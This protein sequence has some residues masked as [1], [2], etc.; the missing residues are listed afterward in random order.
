MKPQYTKRNSASYIAASSKE[1][2]T[3]S[4]SEVFYKPQNPST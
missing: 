1:K 4:S 2:K 3:N